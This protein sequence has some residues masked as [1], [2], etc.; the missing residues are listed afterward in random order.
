MDGFGKLP[1]TL[2]IKGGGDDVAEPIVEP[3]EG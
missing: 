3:G 1:K 2:P